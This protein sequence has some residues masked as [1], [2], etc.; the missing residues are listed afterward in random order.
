MGTYVIPCIQCG[1]QFLW[2]SGNAS[3][4]CKLCQA[5]DTLQK[6]ARRPFS[7]ERMFF[8]IFGGSITISLIALFFMNHWWDL[9]IEIVILFLWNAGWYAY[10]NYSRHEE[11]NTI[12]R[13]VKA[14]DDIIDDITTKKEIDKR[15]ARL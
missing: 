13:F 2:F 9:L 5:E 10:D 11:G 8:L 12:R 14:A 7:Q 3:Q 4:R 6:R 1:Q 15:N